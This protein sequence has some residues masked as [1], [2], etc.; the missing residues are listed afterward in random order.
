M[1]LFWR[2]IGEKPF[3]K[4]RVWETFIIKND[5]EITATTTKNKKTLYK[6]KK[7]KYE[8]SFRNILETKRFSGNR[9]FWKV[10]QPFLRNKE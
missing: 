6:P 8:T 5:R 2:K 4:E 9:N 10:V 7:E 1:L 3:M